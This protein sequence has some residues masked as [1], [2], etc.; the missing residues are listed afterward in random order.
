[1]PIK[2]ALPAASAGITAAGVLHFSY[3]AH[4]AALVV[5][6]GGRCTICGSIAL[7]IATARILLRQVLPASALEPAAA[8]V[9]P[10]SVARVHGRWSKE[11]V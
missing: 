8:P 6:L 2:F 7:A 5:W 1:M 3:A 9:L 10:R 4:V 11:N